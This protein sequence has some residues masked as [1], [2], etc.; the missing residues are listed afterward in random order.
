MRAVGYIRVST[1][2]QA[3]QGVSLDAQQ[4]RILSWI[5]AMDGEH[6]ET[7][8]ESG[9]SG[10][11]APGRRPA[12]SEALKM[13]AG[14]EADT[15]VVLKLD[16]LSRRTRDVLDLVDLSRRQDWGLVSVS[17][18]LDTS[19]ASGRL[20]VTVLAALAEMERDQIAERTTAALA[21][22]RSQGRANSR[23]TPWGWRTA[24]G[25]WEVKAGDRR[26]LIESDLERGILNMVRSWRARGYGCRRVASLL[27]TGGVRN[28]RGGQTWT[29]R[30]AERLI[31]AVED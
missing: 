12:L 22:I 15:L 2:E 10:T 1:E 6:V 14:G 21:E 26:E 7:L 25:D 29:K 3:Q 4:R 30:Q 23:F 9:V 5:E 17:E 20:V 31:A 28:P 16:R 13:L 11:V 27:N 18:S 8:A 24:D 19:T